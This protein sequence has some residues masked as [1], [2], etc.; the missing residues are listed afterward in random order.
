MK[1]LVIGSVWPEPNSSA[2]GENMMA[3]LRGACQHDWQLTFVSSAQHSEHAED[4]SVMGIETAEVALNC[5][6]FDEFVESLSPD[7]VIFD[8]FMTEEQFGWRVEKAVPR[9]IRVLNTEDLHGLREQS[10]LK[11]GNTAHE[12]YFNDVMLREIAS[13]LRCDLTLI[14][15]KKEMQWLQ[16]HANIPATQLVYFPLLPNHTSPS[17]PPFSETKHDSFIGN[18]RHQP[19]WHAVLFLHKVWPQIR[20]QL[21]NAECHIYGAYPPKKATALSNPKSGFL[22]KGWIENADDAFENYRLALAPLSFGAGIKGKLVRAVANRTPS[23]VSQLA[24]EGICEDN[25]WPGLVTHNEDDFVD[26]VVKLYNHETLW[27]ECQTKCNDLLTK[28]HA[29]QNT[30]DLLYERIEKLRTELSTFRQR[31]ILSRVLNHHTLKTSQYMSQWIEA[32]NKLKD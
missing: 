11:T 17:K 29:E 31:H 4:L 8:R 5:S 28:W 16:E 7:I 10:R 3:L 30:Q 23:V 13:I 9:A 20:K 32:K 6:S 22:V 14:I 15:S 1:C 2:A 18:I 26:A 24:T 21:P 25:Q 12:S 19:N 27:S